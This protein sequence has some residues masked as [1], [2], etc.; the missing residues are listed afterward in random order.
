[1]SDSFKALLVTLIDGETQTEF[2]TLERDALPPGEVLVKVAYSSLNY[3]DG[4]AV[5]GRGKIIRRFPMVPG[6][7]LVGTVEESESP[8]FEPGECVVAVGAGLGEQHWG[9]YAE[10]AR[11]NADSL[12]RLPEGLSPQQAMGV[13]TA[14][15][16]AMMAAVALDD[17]WIE[18][19]HGPILVTG[20]SGGVGSMAVAILAHR[21]Y[22]VVAAT[23]RPEMADYL[24][25]LGASEVISRD[26][27]DRPSKPLEG[28][29]WAGAVDTVGGATLATVLATTLIGG[30]VAAVGL[31][32]SA[33]LHTT[34]YPFILR[35]VSL[36]GIDTVNI[37]PAR[38]RAIWARIAEE[39]PGEV[40]DRITRVEPLDRIFDLSEQILAGQIQGRVVLRVGE[41]G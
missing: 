33:E 22:T 15:F 16:A 6:V 13:G 38:R 39:L 23:G 35:G 30:V 37:Q 24:T 28:G 29:R 40:I 25:A 1:M 36:A 19:E 20:A 31:A 21:G 8:L 4:L 17:H 11:L 9:G 26:M 2:T 10:Y 34:V 12:T 18:P 27:L 32:G 41:E 14:G 5:T 3:K 7:D